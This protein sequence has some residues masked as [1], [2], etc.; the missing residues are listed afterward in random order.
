KAK[1]YCPTSDNIWPPNGKF[2]MGRPSNGFSSIP[3]A[4]EEI[5]QGKLLIVVDD[6][7]RENEGDLIIAAS[8]VTPEAIAFMVKHGTGIVCA[9]MKAEQLESL[10]LPLMV[11]DKDNEEKLRTA[12]TITVDAKHGTTTGVSTQDRTTTILALASKDSKAEDFN[13]QG[14]IFP[15]MYREGVVLT[16]PGYTKASVDLALLAGLDLV[17]V[18]CEIVDDDGSMARLPKLLEFAKKHGLKIISIA[19]LIKF[20]HTRIL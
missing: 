12:F 18:I 7:D 5:R 6:E 4:I 11:N 8:L 2:D 17:A 3:E 1:S 10:Q 16:R 13:R 9:C 20:V 15:L 19:E 14:H